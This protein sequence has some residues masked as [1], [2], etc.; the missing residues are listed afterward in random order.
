MPEPTRVGV[1]PESPA[2]PS[3]RKDGDANDR[4]KPDL[5]WSCG[6]AHEE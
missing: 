4:R 1:K 3:E 5:L 6:P 2:K